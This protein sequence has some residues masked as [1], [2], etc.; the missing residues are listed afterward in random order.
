M[1]VEMKLK[2]LITLN[3][4]N[5]EMLKNNMHKLMNPDEYGNRNSSFY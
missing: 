5:K 2:E 4:Y 3:F 1:A